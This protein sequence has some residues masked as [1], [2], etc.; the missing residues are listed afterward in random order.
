M[1]QRRIG[2]DPTGPK[3]LMRLRGSTVPKDFMGEKF[4]GSGNLLLACKAVE[5]MVHVRIIESRLV[6]RAMGQLFSLRAS[7]PR[8]RID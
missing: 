5:G 3:C 6:Y 2:Y 1:K 8:G 7:D 4:A